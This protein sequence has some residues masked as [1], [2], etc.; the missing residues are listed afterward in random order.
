VVE[1]SWA[2]AGDTGRRELMG[3]KVDLIAACRARYGQSPA[4]QFH[5]SPAE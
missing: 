2:R 4:C 3:M 5:G 1:V